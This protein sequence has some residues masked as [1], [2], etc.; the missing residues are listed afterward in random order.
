MFFFIL[1]R[2]SKNVKSTLQNLKVGP[3][4]N[5]T[6]KKCG[7]LPT[8]KVIDQFTPESNYYQYVSDQPTVIGNIHFETKAESKYS[9]VCAAAKRARELVDGAEPMN[10]GDAAKPVTMALQ[11]IAEDKIGYV[12]TNEGIK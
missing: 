1:T 11:E 6:I 10:T 2:G 3:G 4:R 7:K 8:F 9:L 12:Q 5:L